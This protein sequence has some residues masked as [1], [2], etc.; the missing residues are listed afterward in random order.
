MRKLFVA[1]VALVLC[2]AFVPAFAGTQLVGDM[3]G[4]GFGIPANGTLPN[5]GSFFD[6]RSPAE[7]SATNGAQI[8]DVYDALGYA[9][10][11]PSVNDVIFNLSGPITSATLTVNMGDFQSDAFGP[12]DTY[13]NGVFAGQW[14]YADGLN[15]TMIRTYTL[16]PATIASINSTGTFDLTL[17]RNGSGD[18]VTFDYFQLDY[19]TTTPEPASLLLL[20]TGL[21]GMA[22]LRRRK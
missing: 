17:N 13:Y 15:V 21:L 12:I 11:L 5:S 10:G 9:Y 4:F 8:T 22:G 6:N 3:D 16:D 18:Y 2:V 20:G 14:N 19:S 7:A 1:S